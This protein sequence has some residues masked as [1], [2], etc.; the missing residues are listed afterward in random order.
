MTKLNTSI[1]Y[2]DIAIKMI[3]AKLN[4]VHAHILHLKKAQA[5][6]AH[7]DSVALL[8]Y[9]IEVKTKHLWRLRRELFKLRAG[10]FVLRAVK[11]ITRS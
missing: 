9:I 5:R 1:Y 3:R 10:L 8:G 7:R 11:F 2:K 6:S 4:G